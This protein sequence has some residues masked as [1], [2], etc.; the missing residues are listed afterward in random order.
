MPA[1]DPCGAALL[2]P[3][4]A[5]LLLLLLLLLLPLHCAVPGGPSLRRS[6]TMRAQHTLART[7]RASS[8]TA[9]SCAAAPPPPP[10]P[11]SSFAVDTLL[12]AVTTQSNWVAFSLRAAGLSH[13]PYCTTCSAST[14]GAPRFGRP[15]QPAAPSHCSIAVA[16][17]GAGERRPAAAAVALQTP[18][19][20]SHRSASTRVAM[21]AVSREPARAASA[22]PMEL[23]FGVPTSSSLISVGGQARRAQLC[24]TGPPASSC[25]WGQ[26]PSSGQAVAA[27]STGLHPV[28]DSIAHSSSPGAKL[29]RSTR[30]S[31][32]SVAAPTRPPPPHAPTMPAS[33][34]LCS[35]AFHAGESPRAVMYWQP[36]GMEL[37]WITCTMPVH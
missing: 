25:G 9:A 3:A 7:P 12:N 27:H 35:A 23:C 32:C 31:G 24:M 26:Q 4:P 18:R 36:T 28:V 6:A 2:A 13:P 29:A 19:A 11:A 33:C 1:Q 10:L 17:S 16:A 15:A 37:K 30:P 14:T 5:L 20:A 34:K 21:S 8:A 22:W